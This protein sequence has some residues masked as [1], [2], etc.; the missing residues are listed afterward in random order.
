MDISLNANYEK[1]IKEQMATGLYNSVNDI[2]NEALSLLISRKNVSE[3][4]IKQFNEEI[5]KGLEDA[6]NGRILDGAIAFER[7]AKKYE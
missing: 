7:L 6:E 3:E 1:F 4:R 2:M 5:T